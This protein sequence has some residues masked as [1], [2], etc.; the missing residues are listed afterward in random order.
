[1]VARKYCVHTPMLGVC[2][3]GTSKDFM[4]IPSG[5]ILVPMPTQDSQRGLYLRVQWNNRELLVFPQ[6]VAA[7]AVRCELPP[8]SVKR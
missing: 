3:T 5:A 1:M 6:D 2:V 4:Y 8:N 7:C